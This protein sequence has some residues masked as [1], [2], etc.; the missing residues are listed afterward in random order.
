MLL[1][2]RMTLLATD[3]DTTALF[4]PIKLPF[5]PRDLPLDRPPGQIITNR[6]TGVQHE[7]LP[8]TSTCNGWRT[9]A[10]CYCANPAGLGTLHKG[11]GRCMFHDTS[12]ATETRMRLY[13]IRET[14]IGALALELEESDDDPTNIT[15]ELHLARATLLNWIVRY[16]EWQEK[17]TLW[18]EAYARGDVANQPPARMDISRIDALL[19]RV[20]ELALQLE[21]S[22]LRDAISQGEMVEVLREIAVTVETTVTVCPFCKGSLA[23]VLGLIRQGW[24]KIN[25]WNRRGRRKA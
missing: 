17:V 3:T 15:S 4:A 21:E 12:K 8:S 23:P 5:Y 7:I 20:A 1:R 25:L 18:A 22:R 16:D 13:H 6:T 10:Q 9:D 24:Q 19:K 14:A 2:G 11:T